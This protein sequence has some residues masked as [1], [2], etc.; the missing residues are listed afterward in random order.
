MAVDEGLRERKKQ[1]TREAII[2]AAGRLFDENG[3]DGTTV[4]DIA[5]AADIAPRTFF[6]YFPSKESVVFHDF[7]G[8]LDGLRDRLRNREDG[9]DAIDAL[10]AWL[11]VVI[12]EL[13]P[14]KAMERQRRALIDQSPSLALHDRAKIGELEEAIGEAVATDLGMEPEDLR[15]RLVASATSALLTSLETF[16]DDE[17]KGFDRTDPELIET[18]DE[19]LAFLRAG[20]AAF[21]ESPVA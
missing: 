20:M 1:R 10:R 17:E 14:N 16:Y 11:M 6:A 9:E 19:A 7:E 4:A 2:D 18:L 3:F 15:P 21:S 5:A 8:I 13:E 12:E